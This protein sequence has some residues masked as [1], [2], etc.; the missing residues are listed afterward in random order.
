MSH[1][2]SKRTVPMLSDAEEA[3]LQARMAADPDAR[4]M[5][6]EELGRLRPARDVLPPDV[7]AALTKRGRPKS[8]SRL[9]QVTL[10][11]D[12]EALAAFRATGPGWQTRINETVKRAA[13]R[14]GQGG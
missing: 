12:P 14:L 9:V 4:E 3:E 13:K 8:P 1:N 7:F 5:T 2:P 6:E 11:L 10:R